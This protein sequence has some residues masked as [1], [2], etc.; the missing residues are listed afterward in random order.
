MLK[1][2]V[3][4]GVLQTRMRLSGS[5]IQCHQLEKKIKRG[6]YHMLGAP[7]VKVSRIS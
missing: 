4:H 1:A 6:A 2:P 3:G 7:F 5:H